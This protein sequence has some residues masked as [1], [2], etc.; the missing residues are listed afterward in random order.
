MRY[1][2]NAM[3]GT[4]LERAIAYREAG[5]SSARAATLGHFALRV[6][7]LAVAT[8]VLDAAGVAI[9]GRRGRPCARSSY[10]TAT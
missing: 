1:T 2:S 7:D 8:I 10:A 6:T 9:S 3:H 4:R 5:R